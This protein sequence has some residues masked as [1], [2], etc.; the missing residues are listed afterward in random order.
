MWEALH[1]AAARDGKE[2][3]LAD[4]YEKATAERRLKQL[5]PAE[6]TA[7]LV[8]AA[9]YSLGI[10]G[11]AAASDRFLWRVLEVA[12]D[13]AEA[14]HRLERK[15]SLATDKVRLGEL[16]ALVAA[17]PPRPPAVLATA[18][19]H[20]LSLLTGKSPLPDAACRKLFVLM[21]VNQ[22][23]V[24][25]LEAHCRATGRF[26]LACE[27]LEE[28]LAVCPDSPDEVI[29]LRHRLV[30]LYVGDAKAPEKSLVHIEALLAHDPSDQRARAAAERL[31]RI[32]ELAHG[33]AAALQTARRQLR[34]RTD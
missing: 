13:H 3:E 25:V 34:D 8:H 29:E 31:L 7:L 33:A 21:P 18:A 11:D 6:R 4:A 5:Q 32:R 12:P 16:Y 26:G 23:M 9:D 14:F 15:F 22:G 24:E 10:R 30:E 2:A 19:Q 27:V 20:V 17:R 28:K 1:G